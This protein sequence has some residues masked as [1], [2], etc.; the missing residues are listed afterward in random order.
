[1]G[2][3]KKSKQGSQVPSKEPQNSSQ[4][5]SIAI[6]DTMAGLTPLPAFWNMLDVRAKRQVLQI[7]LV[8]T[9]VLVKRQENST[10]HQVH[11]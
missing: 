5:D 2:N 11:S 4:H 1:M 3:K 9:S 6:Q 7:K 8:S 10:L